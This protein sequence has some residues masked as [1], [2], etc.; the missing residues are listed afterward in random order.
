MMAVLAV[1]G[2][3]HTELDREEARRTGQEELASGRTVEGEE[4]CCSVLEEAR[5]TGRG[6]AGH[7]GVGD[8]RAEAGIALAEGLAGEDSVLEAADPEAAGSSRPVAEEGGTAQQ[9]EGSVPAAAEGNG[10]AAAAGI[11]PEE[12]D[13]A[14]GRSLE[15]AAALRQVSW[16]R[17][18]QDMEMS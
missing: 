17:T 11:G 12:G 6:A 4:A 15:V 8:H 2:V 18:K 3:H 10:H 13:T 1:Q 7:T 9:A 5:R 16:Q 14:V